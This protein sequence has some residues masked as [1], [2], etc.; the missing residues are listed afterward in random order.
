VTAPAGGRA[1]RREARRDQTRA[2]RWLLA[3]AAGA[4]LFAVG[5]SV[6]EALHDNPRPG[7]T[8][9]SVTTIRP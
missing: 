1:A 5:V 9:T 2:L 3:V 7:V 6:G 8:T 4:L